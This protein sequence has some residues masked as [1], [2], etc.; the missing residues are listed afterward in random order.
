MDYGNTPEEESG[1]MPEDSIRIQI[2]ARRCLEVL[3]NVSLTI[4]GGFQ[5]HSSIILEKFH[6]G[7]ENI[8]DNFPEGF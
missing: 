4:L 7:S 5:N 8:S 6:A 1:F 3:Q 2:H